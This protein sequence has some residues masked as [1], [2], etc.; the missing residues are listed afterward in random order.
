MKDLGRLYKMSIWLL[1]VIDLD[2]LV[3]AAIDEWDWMGLH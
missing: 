3:Y 2:E 1:F